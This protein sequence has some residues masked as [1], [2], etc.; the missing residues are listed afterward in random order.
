MRRVLGT[1]PAEFWDTVARDNAAWYVATGHTVVD[2]A[3]FA[4]GAVE[5]DSYLAFCD[6]TPT[7][8]AD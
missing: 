1:T 3:F 6:V 2:S 8:L 5:T 4:Q 7:A